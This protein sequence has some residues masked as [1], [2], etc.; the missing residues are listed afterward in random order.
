MHTSCQ[1]YFLEGPIPVHL[2]VACKSLETTRDGYLGVSTGIDV[3]VVSKKRSSWSYN[4]R[5]KIMKT[6]DNIIKI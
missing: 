1:L 4:L 6:L 5:K 3:S 2:N